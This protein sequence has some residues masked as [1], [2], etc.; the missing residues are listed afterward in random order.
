MSKDIV[1]KKPIIP[2]YVNNLLE[3]LNSPDRVTALSALNDPYPDLDF[4]LPGLLAG[5]AGLIVAPGST[6]KSWFAM[7]IACAV[8]AG[9]PVAGG[10]FDAPAKTGRVLI[11]AGEEPNNMLKSRWKTLMTYYRDNG[12]EDFDLAMINANVDIISGHGGLD[13]LIE[14]AAGGTKIGK[15]ATDLIRLKSQNYRLIILDPLA[16]L[17]DLDENNNGSM[18]KVMQMIEYIG[19]ETGATMLALHHANKSATMSGNGDVAAAARGGSALVDACRWLATLSSPTKE[20]AEEMQIEEAMRRFWVKLALP[21]A[22]Y[23]EPLEAQWLNKLKGGVLVKGFVDK[24]KPIVKK[25]AKR[26][27]EN[28]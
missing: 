19:A 28:V 8:A 23:I 15:L 3:K 5:T 20:E 22:N 16:R 6:G 18:T 27:R 21:K 10:V 2:E 12:V 17:H 7:S 11:L 9:L 24:R 4:V 26:G 14:Q 1:H 25:E 13:M